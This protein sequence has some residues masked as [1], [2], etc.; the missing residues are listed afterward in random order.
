[1]ACLREGSPSEPWEGHGIGREEVTKGEMLG[2]GLMDTNTMLLNTPQLPKFW[3][4][5]FQNNFK[6]TSGDSVK[7]NT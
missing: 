4:F 3:H 2:A 5:S 1:M 7:K 6:M